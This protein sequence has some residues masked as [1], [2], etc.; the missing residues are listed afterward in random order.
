[1]GAA[2][3]ARALETAGIALM[4]DDIG[5]LPYLYALAGKTNGVIRRN[6]VVT[7]GVKALVAIGVPIGLATVAVAVVVSDM[8]MRLDVTGNEMRL[9][10]IKSDT[11][12]E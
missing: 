6:I 9:S 1:M 2:E 3:T 7:L 11:L 10:R 5:K 4:G 8:G 12:S